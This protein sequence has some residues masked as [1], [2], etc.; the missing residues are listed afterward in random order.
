VTDPDLPIT[1]DD[2]HAYV[3]GQL[4]PGRRPEIE[5]YLAANPETGRRI[6][7]YQDQRMALRAA[8]AGVSEPLPSKLDLTRILQER[9]RPRAAMW[10]IAAGL[11]LALGVGG[12]GGWF[13]HGP[14]TPNRTTLA[15]SLLEQQALA[16]HTVFAADRRHPIEVG[17]AEEAHLRQWLS[18]RLGRTVVPPDLTAAGYHLIG[19]RL[20]ATEHGAA[21]ALFMYDDAAGKRLSLLLRPMSTDLRVPLTDIG[22]GDMK[23][24]IWIEKGMGYAAVAALPDTELDRIAG[25]IR[26]ELGTG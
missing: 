1:E 11:V 25:H 7:A 21:A 5:R 4:P 23:G 18:N 19:G 6:A 16:T 20:L 15:L 12:A 17:A 3:D 13:L 26:A 8:L 10:R 24:C 9:R 14:A 22:Q 2:L